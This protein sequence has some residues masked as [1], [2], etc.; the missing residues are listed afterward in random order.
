MADNALETHSMET[1]RALALFLG[2]GTV[3]VAL[4][5]ETRISDQASAVEAAKRYLKARCTAEAP[6]KF[7]AEREASQW[8][9]WVELPRT[10][11]SR[12]PA[13]QIVLFFDVSGNL[14]RR[15]EVE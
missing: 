3:A 9:V 1:S 2:A 15:L 5:A 10:S 11:A 7:R 6:C 8:R 14:I 4:A 13:K 12:G